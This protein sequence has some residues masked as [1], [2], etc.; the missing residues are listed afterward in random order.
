MLNNIIFPWSN[1]SIFVDLSFLNDY[2]SQ[3][4]KDELNVSPISNPDL[5]IA[6]DP[7]CTIFAD[8]SVRSDGKVGAA[9]FS[10][11]L[12]VLVRLPNGL[13]I[14]YAEAYA[15][16]LDLQYAKDQN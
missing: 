7:K 3:R 16:L 13:S 15:I 8:G 11:S 5:E 6:F 14:Y 2:S 1:V 9:I 4:N 10:A 12:S